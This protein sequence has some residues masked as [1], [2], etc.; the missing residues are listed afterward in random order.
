MKAAKSLLIEFWRI[1]TTQQRTGLKIEG[2]KQSLI[3][4]IPSARGVY[5][6]FPADFGFVKNALLPKENLQAILPDGKKIMK[7]TIHG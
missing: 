5:L 6:A 7:V 2:G 1:L 3:L 4:L